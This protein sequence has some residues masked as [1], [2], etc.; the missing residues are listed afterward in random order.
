MDL[1]T[2]ILGSN[3][4]DK[5]TVHKRRKAGKVGIVVAYEIGGILADSQ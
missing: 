2:F 3:R 4:E 5:S 1:I